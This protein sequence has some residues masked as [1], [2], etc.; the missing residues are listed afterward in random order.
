MWTEE[1]QRRIYRRDKI[2]LKIRNHL[3]VYASRPLVG[4]DPLIGFPHL[5]EPWAYRGPFTVSE[6]ASYGGSELELESLPI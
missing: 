2:S 6:F 1:E 3:A 5:R 4:S